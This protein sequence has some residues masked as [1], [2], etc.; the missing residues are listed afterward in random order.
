MEVFYQIGAVIG[1]W[2]GYGCSTT[3]SDTASAQWRIP[4]SIQIPLVTALLVGIPFI[5]ETPRFLYKT[6][7]LASAVSV[8]SRLRRLPE[9][10][11]YV[12]RE[13]VLIREELETE[14]GEHTRI[15]CWSRLE[16]ATI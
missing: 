1:F 15:V 4:V 14:R 16:I 7:K 13:V 2:V 12:Q 9:Q 5:P 6:G 10:H 3:L 8:V 11:E